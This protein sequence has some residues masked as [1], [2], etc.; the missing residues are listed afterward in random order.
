MPAKPKPAFPDPAAILPGEA[1]VLANVLTDL[2]DHDAKLVYADWLEERDDKRGPLLRN[3]VTAF[4]AGKKLPPIKAAPELWCKLIGLTLME[5]MRGTTLESLADTVLALVWPSIQIRYARAPERTFPVGTSK[6]GGRPDLP[7][8]AQWPE[9]EGEPLTFLAQFNLAELHKS[10]VAR[11]L[12]AT[13]LLSLFCLYNYEEDF[14]DGN[15]RLL[16]HPDTS[17]LVRREQHPDL[18]ED[19]LAASARFTLTEAPTLPHPDSPWAKELMR[20]VRATDP[21]GVD[22]S[23]LCDS[24]SGGDHLLGHPWT[25]EGDVLGKK[26]VRLLLYITA[27]EITGWWPEDNLMYVTIPAADLKR[28]R[29]DRAKAT[30][31]VV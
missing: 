28:A 1:D 23:N 17:G 21:N 31:Q 18:P 29:F 15:W 7:A 22:Y 4:R 2:S 25:F 16:Y 12:P 8:A 3:F 13:G 14:D 27:N 20:A 24:I 5:K 19:Y 30:L 10:P 9:Y 26:S 6:F 11:P